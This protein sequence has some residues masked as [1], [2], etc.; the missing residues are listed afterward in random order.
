MKSR[1]W[2]WMTVLYVFAALAIPVST[3]AQEQTEGSSSV[4]AGTANPVPL[5]NQLSCPTRQGRA[6]AGSG[7]D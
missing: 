3:A 6:G 5:I 4:D 2:M 1:T 7:W